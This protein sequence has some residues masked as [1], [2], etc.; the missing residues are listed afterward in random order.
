[1]ANLNW[2]IDMRANGGVAILDRPSCTLKHI[3]EVE[4][5]VTYFRVIGKISNGVRVIFYDGAYNLGGKV[6]VAN[7]Q[8]VNVYN[9]NLDGGLQSC[10]I[11]E[12]KDNVTNALLDTI[13]VTFI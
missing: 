6:T 13:Y 10:K 9:L 5:A 3:Y 4:G 8:A 12:I 7:G 1:M 11:I 2:N